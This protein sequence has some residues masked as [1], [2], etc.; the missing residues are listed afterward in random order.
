MSA[1]TKAGIWVGAAEEPELDEVVRVVVDPDPLHLEI[2]DVTQVVCVI[3]ATVAMLVPPDI[4][5][6]ERKTKS[7]QIGTAML[8]EHEEEDD[9]EAELADALDDGPCVEDD[10]CIED[11]PSSPL[12]FKSPPISARVSVKFSISLRSSTFALTESTRLLITSP[13]QLISVETS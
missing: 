8:P 5:I 7:V 9:E 1:P 4:N 10:P 2:V 11:E 13:A 12:S 3:V 6:V